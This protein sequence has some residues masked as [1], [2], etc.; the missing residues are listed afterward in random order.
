M[1]AR[2]HRRKL[3]LAAG[4]CL[5]VDNHLNDNSVNSAA[6]YLPLRSS[7][8][9]LTRLARVNNR[10]RARVRST[11]SGLSNRARFAKRFSSEEAAPARALFSICVFL[12]SMLLTE[13]SVL[14][15][16]Y[17]ARIEYIE[18]IIPELETPR[19]QMFLVYASPLPPSRYDEFNFSRYRGLEDSKVSR[20]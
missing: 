6:R 20:T 1:R 11:R 14:I 15:R 5:N 8:S 13:A 16:T 18:L 2:I 17:A 3:L 9:P 4:E 10:A 7:L 12:V 19:C